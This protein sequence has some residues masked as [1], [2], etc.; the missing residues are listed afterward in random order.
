MSFWRN[1]GEALFDSA[2]A[3]GSKLAAEEHSESAYHN[4]ETFTT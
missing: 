3:T 1:L 4:V 2:A